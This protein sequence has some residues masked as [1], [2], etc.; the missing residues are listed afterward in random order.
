MVASG[1]RVGVYSDYG[2]LRQVVVG[3]LTN[4]VLPAFCNDFVHYNPELQRTIKRTGGRPLD[5]REAFPERFERAVDQIDAL[6]A[7]TNVM[8]CSSDVRV[9]LRTR[10]S[11]T[12]PTCKPGGACSIRP[13][14]SACWPTT[15]WS[16]I[17]AGPTGE[18]SC[19]RYMTRWHRCSRMTRRSGTALRP[20]LSRRRMWAS[21][22]VA[23][24]G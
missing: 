24:P 17:F 12:C 7:I 2:R 15:F 19:S 5:I 3:V 22:V 8:E 4:L 11:S 13:I 20:Y 9:R 16:S 1:L 10:R 21:S 6:V 23:P 14:P 18:R